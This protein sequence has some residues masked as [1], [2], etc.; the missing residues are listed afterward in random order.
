MLEKSF[1]VIAERYYQKALS[2]EQ[3]NIAHTKE[4]YDSNSLNACRGQEEIAFSAD[5][6]LKARLSNYW[7][8]EGNQEF[9]NS[10]K[11]L[12]LE[13]ATL[14]FSQYLKGD[15]PIEKTISESQ[16]YGLLSVI[17][18]KF[19]QV[20]GK[21]EELDIHPQ[22][23]KGLYFAALHRL[24]ESIITYSPQ[25]QPGKAGLI[26]R[27]I[28]ALSR[29]NAMAAKILKKF[30]IPDGDTLEI[31]KTYWTDILKSAFE[32]EVLS[33]DHKISVKYRR[34]IE[35]TLSDH[36][37]YERQIQWISIID[38]MRPPKPTFQK[39]KIKFTK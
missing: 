37:Y 25:K 30:P 2:I 16:R 14:F 38:E 13:A 17:Y 29:E 31:P 6:G 4:L 21:L 24:A 18:G 1:Q 35:W 8:M 10:E 36:Y 27:Q 22:E 32:K 11:D 39:I 9:K 3:K 33:D 7:V 20:C 28:N 23:G 19:N 12:L 5:T 34:S 15:N 26:Q